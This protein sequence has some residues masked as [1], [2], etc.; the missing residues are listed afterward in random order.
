MSRF[1]IRAITVIILIAAAVI[2]IAVVF[3]KDFEPNAEDLF[4]LPVIVTQ[5]TSSDTG[6]TT[7]IKVEASLGGSKKSL[8]EVR[9]IN[10]QEILEDAISAIDYK[11]VVGEDG[12]GII[13]EEIE[14]AIN[15]KLEKNQ[16]SDVYIS[17]IDVGKIKAV[18]NSEGDKD[19]A[20]K[21]QLESYF[22][23]K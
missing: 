18:D 11:D 6:K 13:K 5:N 7:E 3:V 14:E 23:K 9:E 20:R 4:D 1:L 15:L 17:G 8:E 22:G 16:I 12:I 10:Y 19:A 2:I 21:K